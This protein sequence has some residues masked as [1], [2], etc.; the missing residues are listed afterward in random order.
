MRR[1]VSQG[2]VKE[3]DRGGIVDFYRNKRK[4]DRKMQ[5]SLSLGL[6]KKKFNELN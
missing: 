2:R 4:R 6:I 1:S 3:S 5:G